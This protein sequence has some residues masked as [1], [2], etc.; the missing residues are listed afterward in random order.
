MPKLLQGSVIAPQVIRSR[1]CVGHKVQNVHSGSTS[2]IP[3]Y[4]VN[5]RLPQVRVKRGKV[6][7]KF[8]DKGVGA[9]VG[10]K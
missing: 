7:M 6:M 1:G 2:A 5:L 10:G 9:L 4:G 8:R 3:L